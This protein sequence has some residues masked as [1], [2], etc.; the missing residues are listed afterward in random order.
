MRSRTFLAAALLVTMSAGCVKQDTDILARVG[1]RAL[2]K[3]RDATAGL[4]TRLAAYLPASAPAGDSLEERVAQRLR[5]DKAL[6][7][8]KFDVV[9]TGTEIELKGTPTTDDQKRRAAELAEA[10]VGVEKVTDNTVVTAVP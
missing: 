7:G 10:T 6:Q 9:A 3:G 5:T 8:V 2:D 1:R 4:R